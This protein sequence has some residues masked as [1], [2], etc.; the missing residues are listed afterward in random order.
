MEERRVTRGAK[1]PEGFYKDLGLKISRNAEDLTPSTTLPRTLPGTMHDELDKSLALHM[2]SNTMSKQE[3]SGSSAISQKAEVK[4]DPVSAPDPAAPIMASNNNINND[5][6]MAKELLTANEL[7]RP[8]I[9][10]PN[11]LRINMTYLFT[12]KGKRNVSNDLKNNLICII[13]N[14]NGAILTRFRMNTIKTHRM[15]YDSR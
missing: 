11:W 4:V 9:E 12:I 7:M 10:G 2:V 1:I 5:I 14:T 3:G 13:R 15:N 6:A 8:S